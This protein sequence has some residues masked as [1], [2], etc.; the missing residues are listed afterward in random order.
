MNPRVTEINERL[1][2]IDERRTAIAAELEVENADLDTL[3][4]EVRTL[5][6]EYAALQAEK[7]SITEMLCKQ[8]H[9]PEN[10]VLAAKVLALVDTLAERVP[11]WEMACNKELEAAKVAYAAMNRDGK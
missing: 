11:L 7:R 6:D 1:S 8:V 10:E 3:G 4:E 9:L 2:A 5:N